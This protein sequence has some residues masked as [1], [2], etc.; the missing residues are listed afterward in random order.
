MSKKNSTSKKYLRVL[1]IISL[2]FACIA[3]IVG[4]LTIAMRGQYSL[5]DLGL[6]EMVDQ[7]QGEITEE[8]LKIAIGIVFLINGFGDALIGWL[9]I[10][11]ANNP[12][13]STLLLVLLVFSVISG[14]YTLINTGFSNAAAATGNIVNLTVYVLALIAVFDLR[15]QYN[16]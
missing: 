10:R 5:A 8:G 15:G 6:S 12:R 14:I 9:L 13:K 4:I 16:D 2:V 3:L 7:F 11:A 1:G